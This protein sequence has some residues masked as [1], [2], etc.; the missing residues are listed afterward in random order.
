MYLFIF[1]DGNVVKGNIIDISE[2]EFPI[3][4]SDG[5]WIDVKR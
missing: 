2:P 1:E 3:Y 5:G 4:Y